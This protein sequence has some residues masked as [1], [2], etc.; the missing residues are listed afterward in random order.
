[1]L[2]FWIEAAYWLRADGDF[3]LEDK[4]WSPISTFDDMD[5]LKV[6]KV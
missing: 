6:W 1:M 5:F 3:D 2:L 4:N